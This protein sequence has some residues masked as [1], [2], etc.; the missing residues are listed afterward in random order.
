MEANVIRRMIVIITM[1]R[2]IPMFIPPFVPSIFNIGNV[3]GKGD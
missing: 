1:K 2:T 3:S